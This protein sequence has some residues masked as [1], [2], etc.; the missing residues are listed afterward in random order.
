MR[1]LN[2]TLMFLR[3]FPAFREMEEAVRKKSEARQLGAAII[4]SYRSDE[5]KLLKRIESDAALI[6]SLNRH[7]AALEGKI[8]M[9]D[10][11]LAETKQKLK[12]LLPREKRP[13]KNR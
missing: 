5:A 2:L 10:A 13:R 7:I 6:D 3:L 11:M 12:A 9:R 4:R 1:K 8:E